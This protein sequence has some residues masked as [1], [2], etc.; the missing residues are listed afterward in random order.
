MSEKIMYREDKT[1][2]KVY[3]ETYLRGIEQVISDREQNARMKRDCYSA[4]IFQNQEKFRKDLRD[5]LGWPLTE[6]NVC[7]IP[8]VRLEKLTDESRYSIFRMTLEVIDGL[9]ITGLLFRKNESKMPLVVVQHGG[10]GTPELISNFYG[11]TSNYNDML[12]RVLLQD[13][14]VFAPQLLLWK[15]E[16]HQVEHDRVNLDAR[17]KRVGSSI[18]ALEVYAIIRI[19][20]YFSA[21]DYVTNLGMVGF[22]YGGLY[23]LFTTALDARIKSAVSCSFFNTRSEIAWSDWTWFCSAEQFCDAEIA[24]L[25]YPR[26]LCIEVG[27]RD[28]FFA[29][30][31]ARAEMQRLR[32]KCREVGTDWL[33]YIEY[34]GLHEFCQD[35]FAIKRLVEDLNYNLTHCERAVR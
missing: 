32:N 5:M 35:D 14:H 15:G 33:D 28:E 26:R 2:S 4:D 13:V 31:G 6:N 29:I 30:D 8:T 27:A 9:E 18:T 24:C 22:S 1:V 23:T 34:D 10:Y 11:N 3:K 21:Q 20:D 19:N 25:V 12:E 7:T 17:L 16:D